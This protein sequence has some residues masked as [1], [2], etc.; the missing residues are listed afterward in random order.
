MTGTTSTLAGRKGVKSVWRF[1]FRFFC[2]LQWRD[3]FE[4]NEF[5]SQNKFCGQEIWDEVLCREF[6][7]LGRQGMILQLLLWGDCTSKRC[8]TVSAVTSTHCPSPWVPVAGEKNAKMDASDLDI[9]IYVYIYI[10]YVY[11]YMQFY[12]KMKRRKPNKGGI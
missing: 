6:C 2:M 10:C 1:L 7:Q 5:S 3:R 4:I 11:I 9:C 8:F 12:C